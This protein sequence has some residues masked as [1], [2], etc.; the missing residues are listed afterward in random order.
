M[1][2]RQHELLRKLIPQSLDGVAVPVGPALAL[3]QLPLEELLVGLQLSTQL[4]CAGGGLLQAQGESLY[5]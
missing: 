5:P 2:V 3:A 1:A 4:G